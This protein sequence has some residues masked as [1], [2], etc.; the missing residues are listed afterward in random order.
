MKQTETLLKDKCEDVINLRSEY[1]RVQ[2]ISFSFSDPFN[3]NDYENE[4][5]KIKDTELP[6]YREEIKKAKRGRYGTVQK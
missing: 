5:V 3:N 4:Y 6:K 2:N 1:N